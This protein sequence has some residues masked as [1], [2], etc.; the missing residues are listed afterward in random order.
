VWGVPFVKKFTWTKG[1]DE[2]GK[3]QEYDPKQPVQHYIAAVTP[4]RDNK[5]A[6]FCPGNMG[7]KNWPPTAYNPELHLWYIPVIESC[8]R[9]T[10]E[11][12]TPD[13]IKPREFFTGG[14]PSQPFKITGSV[15]AI[16][17]SSGKVV[18]KAE[19]PY[20]MLGGILATPDLVFAGQPSGEVFALDAK[21]LDKR[22]EF[23]TGGGVS[24]PPMSFSVDGRQ[25]IAILVGQGGAWDKW[26]ID[27]TP[28][29]KRMQ[30]GSMLY[31][32][33]L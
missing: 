2:T 12:M 15:T 5:V 17:V 30:P 24:A 29:L 3:P 18:G 33:S 22:W 11:E 8:N 25:Y 7:G 10:V 26:F 31:V 14:G 20:P 27:A 1:L 32:F 19:T 13:K 28:E 16:D 23:N 6:D 9:V 4:S 21:T